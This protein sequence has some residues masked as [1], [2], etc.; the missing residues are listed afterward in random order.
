MCQAASLAGMSCPA[1]KHEQAPRLHYISLPLSHSFSGKASFVDETLFG[2]GKLHSSPGAKSQVWHV[3]AIPEQP[4][5]SGCLNSAHQL[6]LRSLV[7][8]EVIEKT[9]P[10]LKSHS[11]RDEVV[12]VRREDLE[13][14][15]KASPIMV[16]ALV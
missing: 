14:M 10:R 9:S 3:K 13:R 15:I 16:G 4:A 6:A 7:Q 8:V 12:T 11:P 2:S 1:S 5:M